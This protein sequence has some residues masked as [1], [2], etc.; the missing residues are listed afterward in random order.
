MIKFWVKC[1]L[2]C[3]SPAAGALLPLS[4]LNSQTFIETPG[5][6]NCQPQTIPRGDFVASVVDLVVLLD[7]EKMEKLTITINLLLTSVMTCVTQT[8]TT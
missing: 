5:K 7:P 3:P 6:S 4:A 8:S 1:F 2:V